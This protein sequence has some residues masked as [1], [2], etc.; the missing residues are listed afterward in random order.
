MCGEAPTSVVSSPQNA[1]S[2]VSETYDGIVGQTTWELL[3]SQS[4]NA[5]CV[6]DGVLQESCIEIPLTNGVTSIFNNIQ[7]TAG[8]GL[9]GVLVA[10]AVGA[11]GGKFEFSARFQTR[12]CSN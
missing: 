10:K 12:K 3:G 2:F 7:L 11:I 9:Y 6:R 8:N 4:I 5:G 1:S